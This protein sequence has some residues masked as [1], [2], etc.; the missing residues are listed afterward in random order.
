MTI[1]P[2]SIAAVEAAIT[3][4]RSVRAYLPTAVPRQTLER[5]LQVAARAPSGTNTQ[6][7]RVYVLTGAAKLALSHDIRAAFDDPQERARHTEE[8]AYYPLEW[9]SPYVDRRRKLGWDLYALLGIGKADKQRMHEQHARNY[10]FFGAPV[11][12][13]FTI[14][15]VMQQG[16]WL[17]YG[18]FLQNLMVAARAQGLDTC[19]QAAFT[20]FHRIIARH[21][22]LPDNEMVVCGMSLGHADPDAPENAL[23]T[24]REPVAGFARFLEQAPRLQT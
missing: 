24:E 19:P 8:Y 15:R 11:G 10:D 23:V 20:Q 9:R 3:S 6:P 18:T 14:D 5:L 1:D 4:R 22:Q 2:Q 16:S 7:W 12:M 13:I 17:D 21:L